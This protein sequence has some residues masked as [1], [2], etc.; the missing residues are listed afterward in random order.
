MQ[1]NTALPLA[2]AAASS[3]LAG[4]AVVATR[5]LVGRIDPLLLAFLR[6]A[7]A[8]LC[9][10][11]IMFRSIGAIGRGPAMAG[12]DLAAIAALGAI[13]YALYPFLFTAGLSY[14]TAVHGAMMMP[15][16][17]LITLLLAILQGQE[18]LAWLKLAGMGMALAGIVLAF[19]DSLLHEAMPPRAWIGD[20]LMLASLL[21]LSIFNVLGKPYI[22]KY[23][24]LPVTAIAMPVGSLALLAVTVPMGQLQQIPMIVPSDWMLIVFL[25]LGAA[26]LAN[27]LWIHA[28]GQLPASRVA[29][30]ALIPPLVAAIAAAIL[31]GEW[32]SQ[33]ALAGLA[34]VLGGI[35]I[36]SRSRM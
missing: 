18:R 31:L 7:P 26:A 3:L 11:P 19:A 36:S 20:L 2:A 35:W 24:A 34:L 27:Y 14:T 5:D 32:P 33:T 15:L 21:P 6:Y 30:F 8:G 29:Q 22:R 10:I 4:L 9:F 28:L 13:F 17:P 1:N 16:L 23:G 25:S 12:K